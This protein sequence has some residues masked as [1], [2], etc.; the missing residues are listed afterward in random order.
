MSDSKRQDPAT[1]ASAAEDNDSSPKRPWIRIG[2]LLAIVAI[3]IAA[4]FVFDVSSKLEGI[5]NWIRDLGA[6]GPVALIGIYLVSSVAFVPGSILTLAA[7]AIYGVLLGYAWVAIGSVLGAAAA[8][9]VGRTVA[10]A[11]IERKL[12]GNRRFAAIDRAVSRQG[13]KIV[14]LTRLSPV[15][16]F[17]L[18]NYMYG[19]TGI[20]F[21]HY[22]IASWIGMIPGTL[23][24]VY[25]GS[26]ATG[27]AT[28]STAKTVFFIVG[29]IATVVVTVYVTLI[30]KRALAEEIGEPDDEN[31]DEDSTDSDTDER[32]D[33]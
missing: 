12:E 20:P 33:T 6:L 8:F 7:G 9:L 14:M 5:R 25:L 26:A 21:F 10:R 11:P 15:F 30:A 22:V 1:D 23:L 28:G 27:G 17:N 18:Q 19:I 24:Y 16:P 31:A 13:W 2:G 29:L 4:S 32:D 3:A